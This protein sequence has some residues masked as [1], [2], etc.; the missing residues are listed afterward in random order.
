MLPT[1]NALKVPLQ[2]LKGLARD[3]LRRAGTT[4]ACRTRTSTQDSAAE[5]IIAETQCVPGNRLGCLAA[6]TR[7]VLRSD[8]VTRGLLGRGIV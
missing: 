6:R 8:R 5:G 2:F 7:D 4:Y 1:F 3:M